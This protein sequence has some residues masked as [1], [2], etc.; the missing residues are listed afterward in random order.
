MVPVKTGTF[1]FALTLT[2]KDAVLGDFSVQDPNQASAAGAAAWRRA[3]ISAW[4]VGSDREIDEYRPNRHFPGHLRATRKLE[5][6]PHVSLIRVVG[7]FH[8]QSRASEP[9]P[10]ARDECFILE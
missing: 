5:R 1:Y 10:P 8:H 4:A 2:M 7:R 3:A 9:P 6:L